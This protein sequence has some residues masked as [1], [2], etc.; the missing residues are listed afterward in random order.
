MVSR[1]R[2]NKVSIRVRVRFMVWIRGKCP[3]REMSRGKRPTLSLY[4]RLSTAMC[5]YYYSMLLLPFDNHCLKIK[6][7]RPVPQPP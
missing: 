4:A 3:G 5:P 2:V 6:L 1:V 7:G